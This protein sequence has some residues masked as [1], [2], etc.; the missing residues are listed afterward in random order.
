[1]KDEHEEFFTVKFSRA[2]GFA[3][4]AI[5]APVEQDGAEKFK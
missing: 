1:M 5:F 3:D 2:P 4:G